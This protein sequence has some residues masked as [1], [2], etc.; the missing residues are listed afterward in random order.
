MVDSTRRCARC[1][2]DK[3]VTDFYQETNRGRVRIRRSC[4]SCTIAAT[5]AY[6][7]RRNYDLTID[8][9]EAMVVGQG[10]VCAVCRR[11]EADN[12]HLAVDHDHRTNAIRGLLCKRCNT[13]LGMA[14]DDI[15]VLAEAITYLS[16]SRA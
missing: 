2:S 13:L 8:A 10:G 11:P 5:R 9:Y 7:I 1:G 15:E 14:D 6:N 3:P 16:R 4:K 12:G